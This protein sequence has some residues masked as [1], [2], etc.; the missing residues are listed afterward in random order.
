MYT[1]YIHLTKFSPTKPRSSNS[2]YPITTSLSSLESLV[3]LD[4]H[5]RYLTIILCTTPLIVVEKV[6]L[7]V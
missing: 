7:L 6:E 1:R 5:H 3:T 2:K 4:I